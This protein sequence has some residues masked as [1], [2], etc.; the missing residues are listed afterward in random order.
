MNED[1][2]K[3][4]ALLVEYQ[5]AVQLYNTVL[6]VGYQRFLALFTLHGALLVGVFTAQQGWEQI[7]VAIVGL[8]LAAFTI[9]VSEHFAQIFLLRVFQAL[10]IETH[11]NTLI[12]PNH[13]PLL[14]TF[15][16]SEQLLIK[17]PTERSIRFDN[18]GDEY[19]LPQ[20][21]TGTKIHGK[22]PLFVERMLGFFIVFVW[23]LILVK[24][25]I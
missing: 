23:C 10:E 13:K 7:A 24:V 1:E 5:N 11:I 22:H 25:I 21:G 6:S 9:V 15:K 12:T 14:T 2:K 20:G 17:K 4:D 19:Q 8:L 16:R 18:L 3:F